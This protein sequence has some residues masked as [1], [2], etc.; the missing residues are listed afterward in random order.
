MPKICH[1]C[2]VKFEDGPYDPYC[3]L[4]CS[5]HAHPPDATREPE[6]DTEDVVAAGVLSGVE[7]VAEETDQADLDAETE[8]FKT[9]G[10]S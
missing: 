8:E 9:K 5:L 7:R 1:W 3:S 6:P 10:E 2:Y 4:A